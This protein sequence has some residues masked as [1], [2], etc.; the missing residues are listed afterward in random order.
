MLFKK[1][2]QFVLNK[3]IYSILF[4]LVLEYIFFNYQV[5]VGD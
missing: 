4:P 5:T 3:Y 2:I 1:A